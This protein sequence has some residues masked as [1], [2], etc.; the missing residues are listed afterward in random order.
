M[1]ELAAPYLNA[2]RGSEDIA[3]LG[4][5]PEL[6]QLGWPA[7]V[8][9]HAID[10]SAEMI[11][12]VWRLHPLLPSEVHNR[13]WQHMPL[14]DNSV[15]CA[16]GDGS[17]NSLQGIGEFADVLDEVS[18]VL[19][20]GGAMVMRLFVSPD[21][22]A[23]MSDIERAVADGAID[24]FHAL[25]WHVAMAIAEAPDYSVKV[26]DIRDAVVAMFPD[27]EIL[28]ALRGWPR[29]AIDTIDSYEGAETRYTFPTFDALNRACAPYFEIAEVRTG[30]YEIAERCP[31]LLFRPR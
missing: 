27:R 23:G 21:A 31:T 28:T 17:L 8:R 24:I 7:H 25:K 6:V 5:T 4:V 19:K 13:F 20:P 1:L 30:T 11:A 16:A 18:R 9:L 10:M 22:R 14:A 29:E 2:S 3:I 12:K 26:S 15:A